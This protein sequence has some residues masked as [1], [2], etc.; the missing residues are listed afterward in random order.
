MHE[1]SILNRIEQEKNQDVN[2]FNFKHSS[3]KKVEKKES[4]VIYKEKPADDQIH[5]GKLVLGDQ[6]N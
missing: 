5:V 1:F 6:T 3:M 4:S 2:N